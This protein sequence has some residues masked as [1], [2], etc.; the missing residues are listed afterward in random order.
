MD[1]TG[2]YIDQKFTI[3]VDGV[4]GETDIFTLDQVNGLILV[5]TSDLSYKDESF[6]V[7][8]TG[9]LQTL[10]D[11]TQSF[12]DLNYHVF[13]VEYY[14]PCLYGIFE[15]SPDQVLPDIEYTIY[16]GT[17]YTEPLSPFYL[18]ETSCTYNIEYEFYIGNPT[19]ISFDNNAMDFIV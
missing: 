5:E 1:P 18:N 10:P 4:E 15:R 17:P 9:F 19:L 8:I 7:T 16:D 2:C 12:D 3:K 11:D 14:D 13:I 6:L